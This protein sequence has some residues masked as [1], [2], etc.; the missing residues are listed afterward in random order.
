MQKDTTN[1]TIALVGQPNVGKSTI[2]NKLTGQTQHVGNWAGKTVAEERARIHLNDTLIEL[3]DLPGAYSLNGST[4]EE[5]VVRDYLIYNKPD[6]IIVIA[7]AATLEHNLYLL[8][9]ILALP[10]KVVLGVNMMDVAA[11]HGIKIEPN[12]LSAALGLPVV[13][14]CATKQQGLKELLACAVDLARSEA[15]FNPH[16][17]EIRADHRQIYDQVHTLIQGCV[18]EPIPSDWAALKLLEGDQEI[19]QIISE[20][21]GERWEEVQQILRQHDDSMLAIVSGRYEWIARMLR[22]GIAEPRA[23]QLTLTDRIDR[24][25]AHPGWGLIVLM[26]VFAL[27]FWLTYS[28]GSPI[29]AWLENHWLASAANWL[30]NALASAPP[31]LSNLAVHGILAGV[32]S[33]LTLLPIL[34]IFFAAL[35]ILEDVGYLARAAFVMD[36]FMHKMGLHGQSFLPLL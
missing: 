20:Q 28:L 30:S 33:V 8:A 11:Q 6:A 2:F 35:A 3:V 13:A 24:I 26:G 27:L 5:R 21:M 12:V 34:I 18:P 19:T 17:P 16:R 10:N 22:A 9:D 4:P 36:R 25:V 31:W 15:P 23:G 1:L 7:N 29:Q 14:L 32:G